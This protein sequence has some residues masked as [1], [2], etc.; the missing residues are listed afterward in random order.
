MLLLLLLLLMTLLMTAVRDGASKVITFDNTKPRLDAS[1]AILKAHDGTTQRFEENGRFYYHAMGYPACNQTGHINGCVTDPPS[2][3]GRKTCIYGANNSLLVYSSADLSSGSWRLEETVYPSAGGGFPQ[4]T[5]FR[6]QAVYNPTTKKFV[7]WANTAGCHNGACKHVSPSNNGKCAAYNVGVA[8]SAA[9]P[10]TFVGTTEP[11][12]ASMQHT[13]GIGDYALFVD[14]DGTGYIVLT[15]LVDGAGP[16]DMYIF[17]LS[18]DFLSIESSSSVGPLP[19]PNLVEAPAM[20]RRGDTYYAL[21]G[22]CTCMGQC[23]KSP[24]ATENLL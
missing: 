22:G 12:A 1:G 13:G 19:G 11:T 15:H 7:L 8:D 23:K 18:P 5:Y 3:K 6:S 17:K 24:L 14:T 4:C 20:F 21:L 9:G 10:Y 2:G 16:R